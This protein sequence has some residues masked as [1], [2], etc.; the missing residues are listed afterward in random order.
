MHQSMR[1]IAVRHL[2]A[3]VESPERDTVYVA[4][5]AEAATRCRV[6]LE[7]DKLLPVLLSN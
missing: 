3:K 7:H 6:R 1:E 5:T 4:D 2:E